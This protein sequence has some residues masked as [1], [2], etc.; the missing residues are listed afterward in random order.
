MIPLNAVI[1]TQD[2]RIVF[3]VRD[4]N[5]VE[6]RSVTLGSNS[7]TMVQTLSGIYAGDRVIVK[8][9]HDLVDG[10]KVNITGSLAVAPGEE[11]VQ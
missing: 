1:E 11:S 4:D 7:D 8:G 2:G 6:Q 3:V 5:T 9:Q 10:E